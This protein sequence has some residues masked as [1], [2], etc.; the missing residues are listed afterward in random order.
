M[1]KVYQNEDYE[2]NYPNLRFTLKS[3]QVYYND[4][5]SEQKESKFTITQHDW[6]IILRNCDSSKTLSN[7]AKT[8]MGNIKNMINSS[9]SAKVYLSYDAIDDIID[10][11]KWQILQLRKQFAHIF[12]SKWR[13][14]VKIDGVIRKNVIVFQYTA[15]GRDILDNSWKYYKNIKAC[16]F[17]HFPIY[18]DENIKKYRSNAQAHGSDFCKNSNSSIQTESVE[19]IEE[20]KEG[21]VAKVIIDNTPT[22]ETPLKLR[23]VKKRKK[24]QRKKQANSSIKAKVIKL[25]SYSK[26]KSLGE[27]HQLL[28]QAMYDEL[29]SK[30]GREFSNN[31]I[32]Q[33]V[34]AMSKNPTITA[35]FRYKEGFISYMS[36]ALRHELHDS[37]K[38][39]GES[40]RLRVNMTEE[41]RQDGEVEKFLTEI[42]QKAIRHVCP[43]NQLRA[44]LANALEKTKAYQLLSKLKEFKVYGDKAQIH[45]NR[46]LSLTEH[47][48]ALI[49]A[50]VKATYETADFNGNS[51]SIKHLE[52]VVEKPAYDFCLAKFNNSNIYGQN[53][54]SKQSEPLNLP[55]GVWGEA[56]Q[57]LISEYG[58]DTYKHWFSKLTAT[59]DEF[60]KI[61]ELKASSSMIQEWI[62]NNY[63]ES[64]TRIFI[65]MNM[66]FNGIKR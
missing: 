22:N 17:P 15:N 42:E 49:L 43:E 41:D 44:K 24:N 61:I 34:L 5:N 62:D 18:K 45:L 52:F 16:G 33:K 38:T 6:N 60:T 14:L 1:A 2:L 36:L 35:S 32:A 53:L 55:K 65:G 4:F 3:A 47:E 23:N 7:K 31:F 26:P 10:C 51:Q 63:G 59:V 57:K 12:H 39:S 66:R 54:K 9:P 11:K 21:S 46:V 30:S 56:L 25:V 48:K 64:L 19:L 29:R 13:K 28:D 27:M 50:Q 37:V 20:K 40:F 58:V 8:L